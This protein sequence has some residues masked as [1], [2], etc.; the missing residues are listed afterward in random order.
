MLTFL[1]SLLTDL[2]SASRAESIF[3]IDVDKAE[4]AGVVGKIGLT[5]GGS[6]TGEILL[7]STE[8][9]LDTACRVLPLCLVSCG[10][11]FGFTRSLSWY[12]CII[13]VISMMSLFLINS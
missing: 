3:G 8:A 11:C 2:I 1:T 12:A 7:L 4:F 5:V 6:V 9:S 10:E 13:V